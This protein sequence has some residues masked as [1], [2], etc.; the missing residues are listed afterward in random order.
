MK[1]KILKYSIII[2][3]LVTFSC[4]DML[5]VTIRSSITGENFWKS[6]G[7]FEPYLTGIYNRLRSHTD[8]LGFGEDRSEM[9]KQGMNARFTS[10]W[11]HN[12]QPGNTVDWTGYY[13]TIGH[14]NL[15]LEKMDAWQFSNAVLKNRIAAETYAMR[16]AVYFLLARV[17]GD[18]PLV[19]KSVV[20]E[21]EEL[22]PKTPVADVFKQ[23]NADISKSLELFPT[24][25][26]TDK[27]RWSKPAVYA[28][29]ADVKMWSAKVLGGGAAD[30]NAAINAI[31]EVEKSGVALLTSAY[32]T[33]IDNRRNNEIIFSM[34]L[35]RSEFTSGAYTNCMPRVDTSGNSDNASELPLSLIGQQAYALSDMAYA[36]FQKY[37]G[38]KR[39]PRTYVTE[40]S[41]GVVRFHWPNKFIGTKYPDDR[42]PDSDFIVY[43]LSDMLLLKA[44]AY[45]ALN[46]IDNA[47][48]NLNK[49]RQRAGLPN[50]TE[51]S[52]ALV[53]R[54]I[55]DERGRE[56]FNEM[57]RWWDLVRAHKSG[58]IDIY[59]Y[60]PNLIGKTTPIYWPIHTNVLI[61]NDKLIQTQGY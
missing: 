22:Y 43:R 33:V 23:I 52:K 18:V 40:L 20:D 25:G 13:G 44:E 41:K 39:I 3:A 9:W 15:L 53:E 48:L 49:V 35:N 26:Y 1:K 27:Y 17:W 29:L 14:C 55:L 31:S 54:E 42:I 4:E 21:N 32:G 37:P 16:A 28:L 58:V 6:E 47:L 34:Y 50:Y 45:A 46:Q 36:L 57:K 5:D 24:D 2:I 59:Q 60:I 7:D 11:S 56:L 8:Y 19:L 51:T 38:D 10:A 30:L 61:K 12:M